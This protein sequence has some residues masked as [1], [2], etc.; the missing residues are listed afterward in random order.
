MKLTK[1]IIKNLI[2]EELA[3]VYYHSR[4]KHELYDDAS[5]HIGERVW[6][7][8]ERTS[9]RRGKNGMIGVYR[10]TDTGSK[11]GGPY[12][13]TNAIALENCKFFGSRYGAKQFSQEKK[14]YLVAGISGYVSEWNN[15]EQ[16]WNIFSTQSFPEGEEADYNL[17]LGYFHLVNDPDKREIETA[18]AIFFIASE[19]GEWYLSVVNPKFD[20]NNESA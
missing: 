6:V 2:R 12:F 16:D 15:Y 14:R 17:R 19:Q 4:D 3:E 5:N 1:E 7:H 8:T 11:I 10:A 18:D 9:R 20:E 13:K